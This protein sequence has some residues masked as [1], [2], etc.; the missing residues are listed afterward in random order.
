ML[1]LTRSVREKVYITTPSGEQIVV[2]VMEIP[3]TGR[4]RLGFEA[5]PEVVIDREE[6]HEKRTV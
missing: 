6:V 1:V 2:T 4:V 3:Q 5:A